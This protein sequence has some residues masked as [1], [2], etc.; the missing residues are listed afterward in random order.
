M[1]DVIALFAAPAR[2]THQQLRLHRTSLDHVDT[3][4]TGVQGIVAATARLKPDNLECPVE[5]G[6]DGASESVIQVVPFVRRPGVA[7]PFLRDT[8][9][10]GDCQLPIDYE[11]LTVPR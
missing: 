7:T 4:R 2:R 6:D 1:K 9:A 8:D 10:T 5:I 11:Q 3:G